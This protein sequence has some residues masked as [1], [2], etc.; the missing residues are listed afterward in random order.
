MLGQVVQAGVSQVLGGWA[1]GASRG[2]FQEAYGLQTAWILG[3][4][5][6]V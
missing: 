4:I 1:V 3:E 2:G 6:G 5:E